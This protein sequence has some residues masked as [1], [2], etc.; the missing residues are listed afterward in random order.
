M[1]RPRPSKKPRS[2]LQRHNHRTTST[3]GETM[4]NQTLDDL[5]KEELENKLEHM[6]NQLTQKMQGEKA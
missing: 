4:K 1:G 5:S 2:D 6:Q 3:K